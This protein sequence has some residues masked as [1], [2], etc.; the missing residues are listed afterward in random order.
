MRNGGR[1]EGDR[2]R[3]KLV[4]RVECKDAGEGGRK[5]QRKK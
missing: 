3:V 2:E 5:G 1:M 4:G